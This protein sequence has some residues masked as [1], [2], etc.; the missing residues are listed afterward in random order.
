M[1]GASSQQPSVKSVA[2]AA[3]GGPSSLD[4]WQG[5]PENCRNF[6]PVHGPRRTREIREYFCADHGCIECTRPEVGG[7]DRE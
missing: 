2:V 5:W 4:A 3:P 6:D 7:V 1:D